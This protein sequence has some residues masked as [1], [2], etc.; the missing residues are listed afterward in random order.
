MDGITF[1]PNREDTSETLQIRGFDFKEKAKYKK[2]KL[3]NPYHVLLFK[4]DENGKA[5]N[6]ETFTAV[7]TDPHVYTSNL[8]F[9]DF[10]GVIAKQTTK[11][12]KIINEMVEN[13][14]LQALN[15]ENANSESC[16]C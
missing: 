13:L 16:S 14:K 10:Y 9:C 8:I 3:G 1:V 11:S 6:I 12:K 2:T 7:L 5:I 15:H 4:C